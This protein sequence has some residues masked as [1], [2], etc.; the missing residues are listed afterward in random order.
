MKK[1]PGR[2][3]AA[4]IN[5]GGEY[6]T[7]HEGWD[8]PVTQACSVPQTIPLVTG[9]RGFVQ[10]IKTDGRKLFVVKSGH[11][12]LENWGNSHNNL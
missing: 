8:L 2:Q 1:G 11:L 9:Y 7:S 6:Y 10:V 5:S 3:T 4:K 12:Y